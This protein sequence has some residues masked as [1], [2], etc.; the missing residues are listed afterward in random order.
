MVTMHMI[1]GS[2]DDVSSPSFA[3]ERRSGLMTTLLLLLL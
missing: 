1:I 2:C 3:S